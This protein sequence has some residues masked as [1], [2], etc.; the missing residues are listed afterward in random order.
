MKRALLGLMFLLAGCP[1]SQHF[2]IVKEEQSGGELS[3]DRDDKVARPQAE[4][5]MKQRCPHHKYAVV[6]EHEQ[7]GAGTFRG[8][9]TSWRIDYEC[10][11]PEP[12]EEEAPAD[13]GWTP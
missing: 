8:G 4:S 6:S 7:A 5:Y 11:K 13:A 3:I 9:D 12:G 1:S 10:R 2:K